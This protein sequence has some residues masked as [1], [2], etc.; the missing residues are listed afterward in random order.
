MAPAR[1][2]S[3]AR[4]PDC[5]LS[6]AASPSTA[7]RSDEIPPRERAR[8]I[9]YLPQGNV[10]HWPLS[11]ADVVALG[12]TPHADPF[13]GISA[14]DRAAVARALT[15]TETEAFATRPVTTLS[16]GERARVALAR[17]L[18]TQAAVLLADEP[19]VS[20]DP[21][22]QLVVME[23]LRK[24]AHAGGAVLAVVH[25]L[26]LAARFAD[27]VLVMDEGPH[28]RRRGAGGGADGGA[29]R[30][31]VRGRGDDSQ[32][33]KRSGAV[34]G[35]LYTA[36]MTLHLTEK[37]MLFTRMHRRGFINLL[38]GA[39][40]ALPSTARGQQLSPVIGY[41]GATSHGRD[42]VAMAAL[43]QGLKEL[44]FVEGQN[45]TI[46]YRWAEGHYDRLPA[47]A[48]DLVRQKVA[49]IF[50]PASTPA[51]LAAKAAT[52]TIPIVFTLGSDPVAAGLVASLARPG[53]NVTGVSI[54]I[55]LLSA[56]R[57]ELLKTLLPGTKTVAVL[58]NPN[59]ANA[60]P[61]LKETQDAAQ[62]LGL[63]LIR[64]E[65]QHRKRDRRSLC[66]S[67]QT[68]GLRT[69]SSRRWILPQSASAVRCAG[70]APRDTGQLSMARICRSRRS[71][72]LRRQ[73]RRCVASGR[74]LCRP[75]S[76][77]RQARRPA[78]DA[79]DQARA[80][81]QPQDRAGASD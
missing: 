6:K 30:H 59:S 58:M 73:Q 36:S 69:L 49:V 3:F 51:A 45:V 32:G 68:A 65:S 42:S 21:R 22:H 63:E 70:D 17:A 10:F 23:L 53:G 27:R 74:P 7:A 81:H 31:G 66:R 8:R 77:R 43:R 18:A 80:D 39:L 38:G 33:R 78:G 55:N 5:C 19:T 4:W 60:W 28:R 13:S 16:G 79:I 54:L 14:D 75:D 20:L 52:S 44:G 2:P 25:D 71:G 29:D 46:E 56:K 9:A 48:A 67:R 37:R 34:G 35:W 24:A 11:V 47:L 1:P 12:R 15:I 57:L 40:A 26:T 62:K 50:A 64:A 41:L 76:Q 61:D 72:E